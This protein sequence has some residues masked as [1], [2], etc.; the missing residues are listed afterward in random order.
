MRICPACESDLHRTYAFGVEIEV[1]VRCGGTFLDP[2][3]AEAQGVSLDPLFETY[4][5]RD[6]GLSERTCPAHAQ[7]MRR[8][9]VS[10]G[11]GDLAIERAECCGGIFLD[12]GEAQPLAAAARHAA[13]IASRLRVEEVTTSTG[14]VFVLPTDDP[15]ADAPEPPPML[16]MVRGIFAAESG[17]LAASPPIEATE[18]AE[19]SCPRCG[20]VY[21]AERSGTVEIDVCDGCGSMFL[22]YLDVEAKRI[23]TAALFGVRNDGTRVVGR[24]ELPCPACNEAMIAIEV[25]TL[26][27]PIVVDRAEC[28]GGLFFDG[29][30]HEP[31]VRAARIA[32]SAAD[33]ERFLRTGVP[34]SEV[35]NAAAAAWPAI[36]RAEREEERRRRRDA[37]LATAR[38]VDRYFER[39]HR[40]HRRRSRRT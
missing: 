22:D 16:G 29:G 14:A 23:H 25:D 4:G 10:R 18:R 7:P 1:C 11:D 36:E 30:E 21:Q 19:R 9:L 17:P 24:S 33:E 38:A 35:V 39:A 13:E 6:G 27:G 3:E 2:G 40:N 31:F 5:A 37:W 28:C 8:C 20:R 34:S 32:K 12:A 15:F 26:I